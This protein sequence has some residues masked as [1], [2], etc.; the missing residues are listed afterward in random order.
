LEQVEVTEARAPN[1]VDVVTFYR[2]LPGAT[3][4][5]ISALNAALFDHEQAKTIYH[6]DGYVVGLDAA[7]ELLVA[8]SAYWYSVWSHR[9]N[10]AWKGYVEL[11][12]GSADDVAAAAL[13]ASSA[14]TG[15][16]A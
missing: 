5:S 14:E 7:P 4:A 1:D 13:L 12:L 3:Q 15:G 10:Q 8:Q 6:V 2:M 16:N 9:R 11:D